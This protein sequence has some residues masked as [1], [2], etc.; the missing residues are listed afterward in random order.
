MNI[1]NHPFTNHRVDRRLKIPAYFSTSLLQCHN[2]YAVKNDGNRN[3]GGLHGCY[4]AYQY[5]MFVFHVIVPPPPSYFSI[6]K[7]NMVI[8]KEER[9]TMDTETIFSV[10]WDFFCMDPSQSWKIVFLSYVLWTLFRW[11]TTC[12]VVRKCPVV[13]PFLAM[14]RRSINGRVGS[15]L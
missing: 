2:F 13:N 12:I 8:R 4:A 1:A 11:D 7:K 6:Y 3:E 9:L 15:W 5:I 14:C 10:V